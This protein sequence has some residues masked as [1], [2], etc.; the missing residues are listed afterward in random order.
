M[1]E[2]EAGRC[3]LQL[4][5]ERWTGAAAGRGRPGPGKRAGWCGP[6]GPRGHRWLDGRLCKP[7]PLANPPAC[8]LAHW[9]AA[10]RPPRP[11]HSLALFETGSALLTVTCCRLPGW[12]SE[13]SRRSGSSP[14]SP[15]ASSRVLESTLREQGGHLV[16]VRAGAGRRGVVALRDFLYRLSLPLCL[17]SSRSPYHFVTTAQV[18]GTG[19]E[20]GQRGLGTSGCSPRL[21]LSRLGCPATVWAAS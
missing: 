15:P 8:S 7:L 20:G 11:T 2:S 1:V 4:G 3:A 21:A 10:P 19:L 17:P 14:R 9:A 6:R 13:V 16:Q 5:L 12:R 18:Y